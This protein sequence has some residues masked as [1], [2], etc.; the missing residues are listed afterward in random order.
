MPRK[1]PPKRWHS[2]PGQH[3]SGQA[4]PAAEAANSLG[5]VASGGCLATRELQAAQ[6]TRKPVSGRRDGKTPS[7]YWHAEHSTG[8]DQNPWEASKRWPRRQAAGECRQAENSP[9]APG[10]PVQNPS[11][12]IK[13]SSTLATLGPGLQHQSLGAQASGGYHP[14]APG[15]PNPSHMETCKRSP[16]RQTARES[17][18]PTVQE[19]PSPL[20]HSSRRLAAGRPGAT[21]PHW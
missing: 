2:T 17:Y 12:T 9:E 3:C 14:G 4:S 20:G 11:V 16:R 21:R 15:G 10:G 8:P 19:Q 13:R 1:L 7:V 5:G 6:T 18:H